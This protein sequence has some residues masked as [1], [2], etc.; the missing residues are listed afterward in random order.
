MRNGSL[1]SIELAGRWRGQQ[2]LR[3]RIDL[4]VNRKII[5]AHDAARRMHDIA[6]AHVRFR[7]ERTLNPKRSDVLALA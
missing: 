6:V 1:R 2:R 3:V 7:I 4:D 5:A